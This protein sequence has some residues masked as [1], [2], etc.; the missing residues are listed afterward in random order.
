ML[1]PI[2][3]ACCSARTPESAVDAPRVDALARPRYFAGLS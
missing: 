3:P 1:A 2:S